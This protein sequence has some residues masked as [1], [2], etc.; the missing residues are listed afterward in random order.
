MYKKNL[1]FALKEND[2]KKLLSWIML[3]TLICSLSVTA[4]ASADDATVQ[5]TVQ[6]L[7]IMNG[8]ESGNMNLSNSVTRA[9]F[10]KMLV[11]ASVNKDDAKN[12]GYT[13]YVDVPS[14]HWATGYIKVATEQGWMNGYLDGSFRPEETVLL[15]E[16]VTAMLRVLGYS[17]LSGTYPAP[18]MTM[19]TQ[20]DLD[21]DMTA[22]QGQALSRYDCM[23]LFYNMM[24]ATT[25]VGTP[26]ANTLG[27]SLNS[28]GKIDTL[29]LSAQF[30]KGP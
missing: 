25:S 22:I 19:Y 17:N 21:E 23:Y 7:Q 1:T 2:M 24:G 30:T 20:L 8:D 12:V 10:T 29:Q 16:A 27:Y 18:Q 28:E 5:Q 26:Y 4:M 13:L 3:A 15:E 6:Q 14:S 9:E 11:A